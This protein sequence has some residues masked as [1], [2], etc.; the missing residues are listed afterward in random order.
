MLR[1]H[2][3]G[4]NEFGLQEGV[5][6]KSHRKKKSELVLVV[7]GKLVFQTGNNICKGPKV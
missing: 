4:G 2:E 7:E 6:G 5:Q 3:E 1:E